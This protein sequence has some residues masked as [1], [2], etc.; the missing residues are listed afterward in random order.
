ML[1]TLDTIIREKQKLLKIDYFYTPITLLF[2]VYITDVS[3]KLNQN[4]ARVEWDFNFSA[5]RKFGY[6]DKSTHHMVKEVYTNIQSK[7]KINSLLSDSFTLQEKFTRACLF[8]ML[9]YIV[10][11]EGLASFINA[12]KGLKECK[13]ET[14]R[15]K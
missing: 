8:S 7:I 12:N 14:M 15:L 6:G 11:A 13:E 10:A 9:L 1:K 4:I 2:V 5:L 3:N